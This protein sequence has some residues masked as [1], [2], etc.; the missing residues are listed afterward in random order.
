MNKRGSGKQQEQRIGSHVVERYVNH[1]AELD[2]NPNLSK[3]EVA[4]QK[5]IWSTALTNHLRIFAEAF[6]GKPNA[7]QNA[8]TMIREKVAELEL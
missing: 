2:Q 7:P 1:L 4:R 5:R 8:E 3:E 6:S